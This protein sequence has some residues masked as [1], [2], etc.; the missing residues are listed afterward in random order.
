LLF[1]TSSSAAAAHQTGQ[2][3]SDE[4][5]RAEEAEDY[6]DEWLKQH[7][8]YIIT[9]DEAEVFRTLNTP[10]E[11]EAFIE[12]F[13]W[14]RDPD[15]R[16]TNN[17]FKAEHYRRIAYANE[18]FAAGWPGWRTERG[19]IYIIH[20]PPDEIEAHPA[21]GS[22]ERKLHEGGGS[23][24]VYPF[25]IWRYRYIEGVGSNIELEFVDR[26]F[27]GNYALALSPEEKDAFLFVPGAGATLA[28][29]MGLATRRQRPYFSPGFRTYPLM[30]YREQDS[31]FARYENLVNMQRPPQLRYRNLRELVDVDIR[32]DTFP[33]E[34]QAAQLQLDERQTLV[35]ITVGVP[36]RELSFKPVQ[37]GD[38]YLARLAV[39]G[40]VTSLRG[41]IIAEF[42]DEIVTSYRP[43][44]REGVLSGESL[45]Q[46][47]LVLKR[48][49]PQKLDLIVKDLNSDRMSV[50]TR[51]VETGSSLE[52]GLAASSL[53]LSDYIVPIKPSS[54]EEMFVLADVKVRPRLGKSFSARDYFAVYLQIYNFTLD[55]STFSPSFR[56]CYQVLQGGD[57]KLEFIDE[58]GTTVQSL[59]PRRMVLIKRIPLDSL[60]PGNY[61]VRV[62]FEDRIQKTTITLEEGFSVE[63]PRLTASLP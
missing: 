38:S 17:E 52:N 8:A 55:Q 13:W 39:Y 25:E 41:E 2:S 7:V 18:Q 27:D 34:V 49:L 48:G 51:S 62:E 50:Y 61:Q 36:N 63:A 15:R 26:E 57:K 33:I 16:T 10:E 56:I 37:G 46:K 3:S 60:E 5:I 31:A 22:Y 4:Q 14:R 30:G 24:A 9:E 35:P 20:G 19:K 32:Y 40:I 54:G 42:E 12:Q 43:E 21:G 6:H 23:T 1:L 53:I 28:E 59:S 44:T 45:Y 11:K 47:I 29:S 58:V